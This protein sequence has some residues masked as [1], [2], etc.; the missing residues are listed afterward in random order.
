MAT[1]TIYPDSAGDETS[2]PTLFGAATQWQA[3]LVQ[4]FYS[5]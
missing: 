4:M 2:V 1:V 3:C 5:R